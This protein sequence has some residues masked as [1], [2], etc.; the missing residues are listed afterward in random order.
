MFSLK[1]RSNRL[2]EV[3]K[4]IKADACVIKSEAGRRYLTG[5]Y[6][7]NGIVI[8]TAA[9]NRYFLTDPSYEEM[10][11]RSLSGQG[12]T[13]RTVVKKTDLPI[14]INDIFR[15]D[16]I[17]V[18]LLES[19]AISHEDYLEFENSLYA[20]ILPM[21]TQLDKLRTVK[22]FDEVENIK[23][24]QRINEKSFDSLLNFIKP[25]LS[26][27]QV[28]A[29]LV[30]LML[31][32]GSDLG[33]FRICCVSG[34][35]SSLVHGAATDKIIE[36][37][38]NLMLEFGAVYNGY[39]SY[40]AR[41]LSVGKASDEF[42]KAYRVVQDACIIGGLYIKK[43]ISGQDAD[44]HVRNYIAE[45]GYRN[46]FRNS[47]GHGIGIQL[48]E[49]PFLSKSSKDILTDGN[50]LTMEPGVYIKGRFGIRIEDMLYI[51]K[52]GVENLTRTTHDLIE[53]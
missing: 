12:F 18:A 8:V 42:K 23:T 29:K 40:M 3:L 26:E 6:T 13:V 11:T 31:E 33:D 28:Q 2:R 46:Y 30:E 37:G 38:D 48:I 22:D 36:K 51:S 27:K 34:E 47:L 35:N 5:I 21:K 14:Y 44:N 49:A 1:G 20:K 53:L 41:T 45:K 7:A 43:G 15:Q 52:V 17:S 39:H 16:K 32:N 9:G 50:V 25:G 24:A 4:L 19:N 10:A